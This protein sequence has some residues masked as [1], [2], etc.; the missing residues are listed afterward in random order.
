MN[1]C[2]LPPISERDADSRQGHFSKKKLHVNLTKKRPEVGVIKQRPLDSPMD[3]ACR[4]P[5]F[6]FRWLD[7][8]P[9]YNHTKSQKCS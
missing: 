6:C 4:N 9:L 3:F 7:S 2:R 5:Y 1:P 8:V